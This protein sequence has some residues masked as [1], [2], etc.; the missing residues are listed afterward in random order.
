M[1]EDVAGYCKANHLKKRWDWL[2]DWLMDSFAGRI[3]A[4]TVRSERTEAWRLSRQGQFPARHGPDAC[5][6]LVDALC[7]VRSEPCS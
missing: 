6:E 4:G 3:S 1:V 2:M 7:F 5:V